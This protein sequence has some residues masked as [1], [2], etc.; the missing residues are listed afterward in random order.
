MKKRTKIILIVLSILVLI[1]GILFGL[2]L[3]V[4]GGT[5]EENRDINFYIEM[6]SRSEDSFFPKLSALGNM[7]HIDFFYRKQLTI[8]Q[9]EHFYRLTVTYGEEDYSKEKENVFDQYTF[10][11]APITKY[12]EGVSPDFSVGDYFFHTYTEF[13]Y[14][15]SMSFIGF[16]DKERKIMYAYFSDTELDD[17]IDHDFSVFFD[18]YKLM[19]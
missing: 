13:Y 1:F 15:K 2:F 19:D 4:F 11:D 10:F 3:R 8:L 18:R 16:N 5:Y 12:D 6:T 14:A 9:T 7:N 17:I